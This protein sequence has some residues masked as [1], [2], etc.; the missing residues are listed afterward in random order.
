MRATLLGTG[1][2]T[3]VPQVGCGC[4]VCHSADPRDRR[5]RSSALLDTDAGGRLL[6]DCGPDFRAQMLAVDFRRIDAVFITHEHYD[7]IG[8]LDDLRPFSVYGR[9]DVY[10]EDRC[11]AHLEERLPYCFV[12]DKYPGV[13]QIVLKRIRPHEPVSVGGVEVIP[14]RVMHGRLPIVG[15]RVGPFAYITDLHTLPASE[16]ALLE[17]L[18]CLVVNALRIEPHPSHQSL[19]EALALVARLSPRRAYFTHMS[20]DM[21]LHRTIEGR[22]PDN[23][24]LAYDGL[25]IDC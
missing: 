14:V 17:G 19:D 22:L 15:Y 5:L 3:G 23:I 16:L 21:G 6:F 10:A 18:D 4:A 25:I 1:T 24:H 9:V 12:E 11:A 8:G 2:S 7:H 13:P 20:H